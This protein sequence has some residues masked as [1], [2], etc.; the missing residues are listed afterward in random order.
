MEKRRRDGSVR[1][2]ENRHQHPAAFRKEPSGSLKAIE[3][4]E[5][6]APRSAD[7]GGQR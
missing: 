5:V 3:V 2:I 1:T 6:K 7:D 4:L